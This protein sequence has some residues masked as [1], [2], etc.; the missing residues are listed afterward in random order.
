MY[1]CVNDCLIY[2]DRYENE[3]SCPT[4]GQSRNKEGSKQARRAVYY[5]PIG[6]RLRRDFGDETLAEMLQSHHR[7]DPVWITSAHDAMKWH[8]WYSDTGVFGADRRGISLAVNTDGVNT[9]GMAYQ[10]SMWPFLLNNLN[11]PQRLR[12]KAGAMQLYCLVPPVEL[13]PPEEQEKRND[14]YKFPLQ[15]YLN[16]LV[17]E[18]K[19]PRVKLYFD[20]FHREQFRLQVEP[21]L[22]IMD[23]PAFS[24]VMLQLD[25]I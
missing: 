10:Y 18:I 13:K 25:V 3:T 11:L 12:S 24:K 22:Y 2:R 6:P 9:F 21:L 8:D 7:E 15:H 20:A 1:T 14:R 16:L 19:W 23:F 5:M 17:D 4:C